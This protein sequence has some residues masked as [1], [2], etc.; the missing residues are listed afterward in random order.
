MAKRMEA[1]RAI[2]GATAGSAAAA[3]AR[4]RPEH[5]LLYQII[6]QHYPRLLAH[7]ATSGRTLPRHVQREFE[8]YL[9]CGRLEYGF[10]RA[11][12]DG[13][14]VEKFVAFSCKRRGFCLSTGR[15]H[16][17]FPA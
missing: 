16:N 7:L 3:H 17:S 2:Q 1:Q 6:E 13:C 10:L 14:H 11:R 12:C 9:K 15:L 5:S 4:H 8:D